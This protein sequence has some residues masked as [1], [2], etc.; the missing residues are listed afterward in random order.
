MSANV[1]KNFSCFKEIH[2]AICLCKHHTG[3]RGNHKI[4]LED[5]ERNCCH[6]MPLVMPLFRSWAP[7]S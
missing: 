5:L 6:Q 2:S 1:F 7:L 3:R 4:V